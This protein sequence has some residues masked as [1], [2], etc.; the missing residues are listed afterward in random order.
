MLAQGLI[1]VV[2]VIKLF[3]RKSRLPQSLEIEKSLVWC[4]NLNN[5]VKYVKRMQFFM[6]N[7]NS[8]TVYRF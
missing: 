5:N 4:L 6:Q 7:H 1:P 2:N 3:W 8:K